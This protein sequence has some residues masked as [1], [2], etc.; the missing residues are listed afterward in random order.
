MTVWLTCFFAYLAKAAL[1]ERDGMVSVSLANQRRQIILTSPKLTPLSPPSLNHLHHHNRRR[2]KVAE[3]LDMVARA[4]KKLGRPAEEEQNAYPNSNADPRPVS[5]DEGLLPS[6]VLPLPAPKHA[7]SPKWKPRPPIEFFLSGH[8]QSAKAAGKAGPA[9][10]KQGSSSV[11]AA[12]GSASASAS[13]SAAASSVDYDYD[14]YELQRSIESSDEPRGAG[15][16]TGLAGLDSELSD[17]EGEGED[18]AEQRLNTECEELRQ[19]LEDKIGAA[20]TAGHIKSPAKRTKEK[21]VS[22]FSTGGAL[23]AAGALQHWSL[24][25]G[26]ADR[27]ENSMAAALLQQWAEEDAADEQGGGGGGGGDEAQDS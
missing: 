17:G 7:M 1:H 6:S 14:I 12:A 19:K 2:G 24:V 9:G 27:F 25:D 16:A 26:G 23:T 20:I 4:R 11:K 13:A 21:E 3:L 18:E 5:L 22:S 15:G 8:R 10:G